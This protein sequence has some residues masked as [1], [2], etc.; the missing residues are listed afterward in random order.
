MGAHTRI[1]EKGQVVVPKATRD[2]LGW[3]PGTELD[4]VES[5]DA[6]ILRPRR[7]VGQL[8]LKEGLARLRA[9]VRYDGPTVPVEALNW[10]PDADDDRA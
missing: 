1:S 6:I 7:P 5:T 2:R 9:V 8:T 10:S 4:I 3:A